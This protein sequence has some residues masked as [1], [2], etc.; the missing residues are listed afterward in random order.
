MHPTY[1]RDCAVAVITLDDGKVNAVSFD[2]LEALRGYLDQAAAEARAVV[3]TG[4]AGCFCAGFDLEIMQQPADAP[5]LVKAGFALCADLLAYRLP[6]VMAAPG[7]ALAMG[8][9]LLLAAD[10][11]IGADGDYRIGLNETRI[12]I[13]VPPLAQTLARAR[14]APTWLART[15]LNAEMLTP[16]A[17]CQAGFFDRVTI[18]EPVLHDALQAA[19]DLADLHPGAFEQTKQHLYAD[20]VRALRALLQQELVL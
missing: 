3:M 13:A 4:R 11:R 16:A 15:V 2:L 7:H 20:T 6:V 18:S 1:Q 17:A 9:F 10:L 5:R 19:G 14:L 12:G 8:A